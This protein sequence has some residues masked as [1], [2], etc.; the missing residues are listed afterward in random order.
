[1]IVILLRT[2]AVIIG[3][4]YKW[5]QKVAVI[6]DNRRYFS[7]V[8]AVPSFVQKKCVSYL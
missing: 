2:I 7:A 1:M 6:N 3:N 8:I 4:R 5:G